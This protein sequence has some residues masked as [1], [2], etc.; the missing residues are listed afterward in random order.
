MTIQGCCDHCYDSIFY[1]T[2]N[3]KEEIVDQK[4]ET[5]ELQGDNQSNFKLKLPSLFVQVFKEWAHK[6]HKIQMKLR[7]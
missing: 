3:C 4:R 6:I 2:R 1:L 5:Y 7:Y